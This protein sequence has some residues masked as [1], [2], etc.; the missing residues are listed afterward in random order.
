MGRNP[1]IEALKAGRDIEKIYIAG[2]AGGSL[3]KI[4]ALAGEKGIPVHFE[5]KRALDKLAP[6]N[7]QGVVAFVSAYNYCEIEDIISLAKERDEAPFVILLTGIEDPHNLGA[8]IRSAEAA[9]VHGVIIPKRRAAGITAAAVKA[10]AG[11]TEYMLCAKVANIAQAIDK[12]KGM[13]LWICACDMGGDVYYNSNLTGAIG[14][15]IGGEGTGIGRL[16]REKCDFVLS[17]PMAGKINSLNASNAA[18]I[19]M[20]EVRR[21]RNGK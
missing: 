14:I 19:M 3:E 8:V 12:L 17:I 18:A 16:I 21:Q 4:T 20:Y 2:A 11:A 1:V 9:G 6:G 5:E 10:S 7:H 13:G 15:V